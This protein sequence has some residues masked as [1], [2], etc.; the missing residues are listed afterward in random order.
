MPEAKRTVPIP[1][2]TLAA[3]YKELKEQQLLLT[4]EITFP[5]AGDQQYMKLTYPW[6]EGPNLE[7]SIA[8]EKIAKSRGLGELH[9]YAEARGIVDTPE[10]YDAFR[11][12]DVLQPGEWTYTR[13]KKAED[14]SR[15]AL[16][17]RY[18]YNRRLLASDDY[19]PD[20]AAPVVLLKQAGNGIGTQKTGGAVDLIRGELEDVAKAKKEAAGERD[21]AQA[22]VEKLQKKEKEL[23]GML[24]EAEQAAKKKEEAEEQEKALLAR[25]PMLRNR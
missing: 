4:T 19:G 15:A 13:D 20:S 2:E 16:L 6:N 8:I 21:A 1:A 14:G 7:Q 18:G 5:R 25:L 3:F 24:P 10:L 9:S 23:M 17:L 12:G 11:E 22:K